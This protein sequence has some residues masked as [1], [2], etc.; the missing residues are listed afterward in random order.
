MDNGVMKEELRQALEDAFFKALVAL[1]DRA[2]ELDWFARCTT[3]PNAPHYTWTPPEYMVGDTIAFVQDGQVISG[4]CTGV[5]T[6]YDNGVAWH[7]YIVTNYHARLN[8]V[9]GFRW[10]VYPNM[11]VQLP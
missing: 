4:E 7:V 8:G 10:R 6:T 5:N 11:I 2:K 9:R 3:V 1:G